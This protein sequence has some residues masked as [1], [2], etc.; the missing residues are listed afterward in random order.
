[1][2]EEVAVKLHNQAATTAQAPASDLANTLFLAGLGALALARDTAKLTIE[3]MKARGLEVKQQG[4]V[5]VSNLAQALPLPFT[6]TGSQQSVDSTNQGLAKLLHR[7]NIPTKRDIDEL[8]TRIDQL[9]QRIS[10]LHEEGTK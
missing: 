10:Q 8:N 2:S 5:A 7:L 6:Q 1:M 3:Q 9:N 4:E